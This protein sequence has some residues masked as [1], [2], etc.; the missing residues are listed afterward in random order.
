[1]VQNA[2]GR[3]FKRIA[4]LLFAAIALAATPA[5]ASLLSA[6]WFTISSANPDTD[7]TITGVVPGLVNSTLG[8]NGLPVRSAL[9]AAQPA[10]S[11][12]NLKD[13]DLVTGELQWWTPH[14]T[15]T[16][17]PF[18]PTTVA[19]PFNVSSN[20]FPG[21]GASNGGANGFTSAHFYGTFSLPTAGSITLNLGSDDD[22]WVFIDGNLV[23]D[24]GGVH[25]LVIAP[26][27]T[28]ALAAGTHTIDVFFADRHVVQSG[29]AFS[30]TVEFAPSSV[31]EPS[32][33]ALLGLAFAGLGFARRGKLH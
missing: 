22:A 8:P 29:L 19:I 6:D 2:L 15:V 3:G 28:G 23:I 18:Y 20:L 4:V 7:L 30:A 13:I 25:G 24:N 9:S 14:A 10:A 33:L 16:T 1:M 21:G 5:R 31:P 17:D 27:M 11:S 26:T 32:I 12:A